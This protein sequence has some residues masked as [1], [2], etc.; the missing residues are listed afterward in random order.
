LF[1]RLAEQ[2]VAVDPAP[3]RTIIGKPENPGDS[4]GSGQ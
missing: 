4:V 3:Y 2:A 1:H